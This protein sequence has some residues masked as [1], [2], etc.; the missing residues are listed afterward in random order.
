MTVIEKIAMICHEANRAYCISIG[1]HSQPRWEDAPEWQKQSA[2]DGVKYRTANPGVTAAEM[3]QNWLNHKVADGWRLGP[4]KDAEK[5]EHPCMV[6]YSQLPWEQRA[7]D[8]LFSA[9]F[10]SLMSDDEE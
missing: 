1:D 10:D 9:I 8:H 4:V 2:I 5:K 7:K 6:P 3:H